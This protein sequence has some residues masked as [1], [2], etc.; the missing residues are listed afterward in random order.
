MQFDVMALKMVQVQLQ[1]VKGKGKG[2]VPPE[3]ITTLT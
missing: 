2:K 3:G 1:H